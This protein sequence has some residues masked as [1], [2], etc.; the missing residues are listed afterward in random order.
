[1]GYT[2]KQVS[3]LNDKQFGVAERLE[4]WPRLR[5]SPVQFPLNAEFL[6]QGWFSG[7]AC[8]TLPTVHRLTRGSDPVYAVFGDKGNGLSSEFLDP[9]GTVRVLGPHAAAMIPLK[10]PNRSEQVSDLQ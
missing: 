1:M 2:K 9:V 10:Y 6:A 7:G 4:R 8:R 5:R 3:T